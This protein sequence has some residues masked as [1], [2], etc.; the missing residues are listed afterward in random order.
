MLK[1]IFIQVN[2]NIQCTGK[3]DLVISSY[4]KKTIMFIHNKITSTLLQIKYKTRIKVIFLNL[5]C[6][7]HLHFINMCVQEDECEFYKTIFEN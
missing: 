4:T 6:Y 1:I 2:Y 5:L 7:K 3:T